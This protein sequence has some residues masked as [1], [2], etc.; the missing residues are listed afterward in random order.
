[1]KPCVK[2]FLLTCHPPGA[3]LS[4][5]AP[6]SSS[7][8]F[9]EMKLFLTPG[10]LH[11]LFPLPRHFTTLPPF[12]TSFPS[13]FVLLSQLWVASFE[14]LPFSITPIVITLIRSYCF[15]MHLSQFSKIVIC[16]IISLLSACPGIAPF[17]LTGLIT[18]VRY[19]YFW[20]YLFLYLLAPPILGSMQ[21]WFCFLLYPVVS[22]MAGML[23]VLN[24]YFLN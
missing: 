4:I 23:S 1:M 24:K 9:S 5:Q 19:S 17:F 18:I 16:V 6:Y 10:L 13:S 21:T 11:M 15:P 7:L 22:T 8:C 12:C 2:Q 3:P 20:N 14:K